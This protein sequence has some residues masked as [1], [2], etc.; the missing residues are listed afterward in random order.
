L[1]GVSVNQTSEEHDGGKSEPLHQPKVAS[2]KKARGLAKDLE[3]ARTGLEEQKKAAEGYLERLMR[4]QAEFENYRKRMDREKED[5]VRY[6]SENI[7]RALVDV[8][9]NLERAVD[10]GEKSPGSGDLLQGIRMT[11][12]QLKEVL[13]AEGLEP[14]EAVG[15][16]FDPDYHEAVSRAPSKEP[17]NLVVKEYMR[18]YLLNSKVIRPAKVEVSTGEP[19]KD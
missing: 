3:E 19:D 14:I 1:G 11:L 8:Y 16:P 10:A 18:G 15:K 7:V 12:D 2:K 17:E 13:A 4:L 9:E 6:A 5:N